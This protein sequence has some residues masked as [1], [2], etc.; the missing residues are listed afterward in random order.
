MNSHSSSQPVVKQKLGA[1]GLAL[2]AVVVVVSLN[3]RPVLTAVGPISDLIQKGAGISTSAMGLLAAVPVLCMGIGAFAT[4]WV[5]RKIGMDLAV[6]VSLVA[7]ALT[8]AVRSFVP[9]VGLWLG[10]VGIG[11]AIGVLNGVLP[12][13]IKRD[14]PKFSTMVMGIFS[15]ALTLGAALAAGVAVPIAGATSWRVATG[16][17]LILVIIGVFAWMWSMR[18]RARS[19]WETEEEPEVTEESTVKSVNVWTNPMAWTITAFMGLQCFLFYTMVQWL[20]DIEKSLGVSAESAGMHMMLFQISGLAATLI[21]TAV[22]GERADQRMVAVAMGII[23]C[24]SLTGLLLVPS[25]SFMWVLIMGFGTGVSFN[26]ALSFIST[27]TADATQA[28]AVSGMSQ[29]IGYLIA[30]FGPML[31]GVMAPSMGWNAVLVMTLVVAAGM[32]ALGLIAGRPVKIG[33]PA[34]K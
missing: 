14:F 30:A 8:T 2:I 4:P 20:P 23:W 33:M 1:L 18:A 28:S 32:T 11:L 12:P 3:L 25:L 7:L 21:V 31:A 16:V 17:W 9:G 13:I 5:I 10:T 15:A 29:S 6:V 26:L 34:S 19:G 22:Q 27:R 24:G